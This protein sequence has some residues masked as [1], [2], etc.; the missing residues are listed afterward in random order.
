MN[1]PRCAS[2]GS[3]LPA[4]APRSSCPACLLRAGLDGASAATGYRPL[5][6]SMDRV[7]GSSRVPMGR[8]PVP[9]LLRRDSGGSWVTSIS[10]CSRRPWA[11]RRAIGLLFSRRPPD[12][13]GILPGR[14]IFQL[15]AGHHHIEIR[16]PGYQTM[17]FDV[18]IAAG[19]VTPFQGMLERD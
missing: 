8:G 11:N 12:N 1:V 3:P 14:H 5:G 16:T 2:C 19:E 15:P 10:G 13:L 6:E 4:D 9:T 7:A 18:D 17:S